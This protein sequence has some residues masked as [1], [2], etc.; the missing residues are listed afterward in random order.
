MILSSEPDT[1]YFLSGE[2]ATDK[3]PSGCPCN[4]LITECL[5]TSHPLLSCTVFMYCFKYSLLIY[6]YIG[7]NGS[8]DRYICGMLCEIGIKFL[9]TKSD[10]SFTSNARFL[11]IF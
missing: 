4:I 10:V 11:S 5:L 9:T 2:N 8:T 1:T 3:T 7:E 6:E